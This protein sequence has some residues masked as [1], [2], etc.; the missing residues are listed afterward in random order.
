MAPN[1]DDDEKILVSEPPIE[2]YNIK[3]TQETT[4]DILIKNSQDARLKNSFKYKL[5]NYDILS[6]LTKASLEGHQEAKILDFNFFR[7]SL[8]P[9]GNDNIFDAEKEVYSVKRDCNSLKLYFGNYSN[10]ILKLHNLK[11]TYDE[12]VVDNKI[13]SCCVKATW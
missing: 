1:G 3:K 9:R 12:I 5:F 4:R 13:N 11:I 7:S 2:I 6:I 10:H 8:N